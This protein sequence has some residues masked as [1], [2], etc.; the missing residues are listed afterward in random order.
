ML[1]K[2]FI[3]EISKVTESFKDYLFSNYFT[4]ITTF[5]KLLRNIS[6]FL[7]IEIFFEEI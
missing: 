7:Q 1:R 3:L 5:T 2:L 6:S 4:I